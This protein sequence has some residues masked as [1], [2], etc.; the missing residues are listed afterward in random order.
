MSHSRV[1]V[2]Q[3][4]SLPSSPPVREAL[5]VGMERG[6][7]AWL[8]GSIDRPAVMLQ[9]GHAALPHTQRGPSDF[10]PAVDSVCESEHSGLTL[11]P[12]SRGTCDAAFGTVVPDRF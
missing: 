10:S 1:N 4:D 11:M 7:R 9:A 3:R 12:S 8:S 5:S 6:T 2:A